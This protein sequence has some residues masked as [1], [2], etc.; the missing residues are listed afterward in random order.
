MLR[1]HDV[2]HVYIAGLATDY[3][4]KNTVLDAVREGFDVTVRKPM[5]SAAST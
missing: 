2:D 1:E 3:C 5:R 4:V